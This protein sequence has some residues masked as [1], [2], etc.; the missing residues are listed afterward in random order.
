MLIKI[1]LQRL[2]GSDYLGILGVARRA[3]LK[4]M[5][6]ERLDWCGLVS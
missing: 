3:I 6:E 1:L 2:K 5:Y 4:S